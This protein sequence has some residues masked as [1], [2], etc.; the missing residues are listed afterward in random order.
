MKELLLS[1]KQEETHISLCVKL[2]EAIGSYEYQAYQEEHQINFS[3]MCI[4][5]LEEMLE[6]VK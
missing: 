1:S 3:D 4:D 6:K 5:E 2:L